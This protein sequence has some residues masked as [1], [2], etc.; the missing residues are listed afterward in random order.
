MNTSEKKKPIA[1]DPPVSRAEMMALINTLSAKIDALS[2]TVA[3]SNE[4]VTTLMTQVDEAV[5]FGNENLHVLNKRAFH[6]EFARIVRL[7]RRHNLG[8]CLLYI[9]INRFRDI[10]AEFGRRGGDV[11]LD[12]VAKEL[13]TLLRT[14]D[15]VGRLGAD[16]L[17]AVII[18]AESPVTVANE[19]A[20]RL[21]SHFAATPVNYLNKQIPVTLS[22][23]VQILEK[24][25]WI[26][27]AIN[28]AVLDAVQKRHSVA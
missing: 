25:M 15:I 8:I 10:N 18:H 4:K 2:Q 14:S 22:T 6:R 12:K 11:V 27:Q 24:T 13:Q 17:G 20:G 16:E 9:N 7:S 3:E 19:K 1:S 23:G 28:M 21:V 26:D 5:E